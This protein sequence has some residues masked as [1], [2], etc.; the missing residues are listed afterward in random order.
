HGSR[1]FAVGARVARYDRTCRQQLAAVH[2]SMWEYARATFCDDT[3]DGSR[4][5]SIA[6]S[7]VSTSSATACGALADASSS[8]SSKSSRFFACC[9]PTLMPSADRPSSAA[10]SQNSSPPIQL[11]RAAVRPSAT[12]AMTTRRLGPGGNSFMLDVSVVLC[13]DLRRDHEVGP[14]THAYPLVVRTYV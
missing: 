13:G 2:S 6:A 1:C 8:R 5:S 14:V 3:F 10:T 11:I 12:P 4:A 9:S 7:I